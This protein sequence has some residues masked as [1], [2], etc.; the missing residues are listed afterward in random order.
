MA[1]D[2]KLGYHLVLDTMYEEV[3]KWRTDKLQ[4]IV[5]NQYYGERDKQMCRQIILERK[6]KKLDMVVIPDV[7]PVCCTIRSIMVKPD[8]LECSRCGSFIMYEG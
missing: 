7:C 2:G 4:Y 6:L 1:V 3:V 8:R 5:D